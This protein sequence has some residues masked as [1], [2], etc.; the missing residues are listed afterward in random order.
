[1]FDFK[2]L[3]TF[4]AVVAL[5]SFRRAAERLNTT[6]PAVSQRIAGLERALGTRLID[7]DTRRI[8]PTPPGRALL[9]FAER[10]VQ[11]RVETIRAIADPAEVSGTLRIG[12]SETIVHTWL[13]EL[14]RRANS[15][16]PRLSLE[17]EVDISPRLLDRLTAREID[18]ALMVGPVAAPGIQS[19][20][21]ARYPVAFVASPDLERPGPGAGIE[22]LSRYPLVTFSRGTKPFQAV[23]DLFRRRPDLPARL[24]ATA[25]LGTAVRLSLDGIAIA[26]IPNV[27]VAREIARGDL[28]VIDTTCRLPD[29][30]FVAAWIGDRASLAVDALVGMAVEIAGEA[31]GRGGAVPRRPRTGTRHAASGRRQ[32]R[33]RRSRT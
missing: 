18:V 10:I 11:L 25:S 32:G 22:E 28:V 31:H 2:D 16:L 27:V 14:L 13:S 17:I 19:C 3:D 20:P 23:H 24:H 8:M 29:L 26:A 7:R 6:Q 5:G 9:A 1:M 4:L 15:A 21:L 30:D 33:P 12:A